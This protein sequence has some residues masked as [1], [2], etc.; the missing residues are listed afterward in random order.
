MT[1]ASFSQ[2]PAEKTWRPE[3]TEAWRSAAKPSPGLNREP[4]FATR[5]IVGTRPCFVNPFLP[6]TVDARPLTPLIRR[7]IIQLC[8]VWIVAI[9]LYGGPGDNCTED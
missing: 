5:R 2:I 1:C 6:F 8:S 9:M 3:E 7:S 4:W